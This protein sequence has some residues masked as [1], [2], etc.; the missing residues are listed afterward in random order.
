M[1]TNVNKLINT[2]RCILLLTFY[3]PCQ[4][5]F[6]FLPRQNPITA[7]GTF[8]LSNQPDWVTTYR[9]LASIASSS[10]LFTLPPCFSCKLFT[11]A[12][13]LD[14][15]KKYSNESYCRVYE[16]YFCIFEE[17]LCCMHRNLTW[18][19]KKTEDDN[20]TGF[21]F[22]I[23]VLDIQPW[24]FYQIFMWVPFFFFEVNYALWISFRF[25]HSSFFF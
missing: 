21:L 2:D 19:K 20:F 24:P 11:F 22:F 7:G 10:G 14:A 9:S 12:R 16:K 23:C 3:L 25:F 6:C 5:A 1:H 8:W 18:S 17:C 13:T 15:A 4:N